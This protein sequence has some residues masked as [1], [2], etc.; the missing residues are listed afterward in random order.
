MHTYTLQLNLQF[1]VNIQLKAQGPDNEWR[2]GVRNAV[3]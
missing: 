2:P 3:S 1:T